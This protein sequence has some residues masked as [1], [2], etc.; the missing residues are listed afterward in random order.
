[1]L[2]LYSFTAISKVDQTNTSQ[3]RYMKGTVVHVVTCGVETDYNSLCLVI[4]EHN[5]VDK[6]VTV[7]GK[8]DVGSVV[9]KECRV[10]LGSVQCKEDWKNYINEDFLTGGIYI[11]DNT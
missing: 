11:K 5:G 2:A 3:K 7:L 9:Y 1:M 4:I 6:P 10:K 8:V